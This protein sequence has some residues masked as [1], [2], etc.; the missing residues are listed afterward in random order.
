MF[1]WDLSYSVNVK[2]MDDQHKVWIEI[3][4]KLYN[5]IRE[6]LSHSILEDVLKELEDYTK[7]HFKEEEFFEIEDTAEKE[8]PK[9]KF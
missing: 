3:I 9:V 2:R 6:G 7:Y 1:E 5:S 4:Q 8:V